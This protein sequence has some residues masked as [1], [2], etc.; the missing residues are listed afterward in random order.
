MIY[1]NNLGRVVAEG[2]VNVNSRKFRSAWTELVELNYTAQ[3]LKNMFDSVEFLRGFIGDAQTNNA[4]SLS[5]VKDCSREK[6]YYIKQINQLKI[7]HCQMLNTMGQKLEQLSV[8]RSFTKVILP[9]YIFPICY[10]LLV[11]FFTGWQAWVEFDKSPVHA[12]VAK[13]CLLALL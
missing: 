2:T 8:K 12:E 4:L 1:L 3:D 11:L 9:Y 10:A 7:E 13:S 6:E 5:I